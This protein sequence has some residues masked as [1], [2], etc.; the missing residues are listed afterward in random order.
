MDSGILYPVSYIKSE[1][2]GANVG[3]GRP[4]EEYA[5]VQKREVNS[6]D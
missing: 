5:L 4:V 1:L 2:K 3:V 6:W